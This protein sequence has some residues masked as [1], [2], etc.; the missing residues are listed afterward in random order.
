MWLHTTSEDVLGTLSSGA[1][2]A[3][4]KFSYG[5]H[6]GE[7]TGRAVYPYDSKH[8]ISGDVL[9]VN[10]PSSYDLGS[11][12]TNTNAAMYGENSSGRYKFNHMAGVMRF[13]F[14]NVN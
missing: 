6:F 1:G 14:K 4:A 7:L 5:A 12:L 11:T 13:K 10:M 3:S 2:T 9:S 8:S